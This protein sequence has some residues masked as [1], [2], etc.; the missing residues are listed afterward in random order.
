MTMIVSDVFLTFCMF[1]GKGNRANCLVITFR[2]ALILVM[3]IGGKNASKL[4]GKMVDVLSRYYAGDL[5]LIPELRHNAESDDPVAEMARDSIR[6]DP[7]PA[8]GVPAPAIPFQSERMVEEGPA[9][10][11]GE[12]PGMAREDSRVGLGEKRPID[13]DDGDRKMEQE[14]RMLRLVERKK[15]LERQDL[16][17]V[18][19]K[20]ALER[21]E[22]DHA[23]V[24]YKMVASDAKF[25]QE[26]LAAVKERTLKIVMSLGSE[27]VDVSG[28]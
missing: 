19:R 7:F 18:E 16:D 15:E 23:L 2:G 17:I 24:T 5:S 13:Q 28:M 21:T 12:P 6:N 9:P 22:I 8:D 27:G 20:K 26:M 14:E 4:R 25:D 10:A 1:P 3:R 11:D